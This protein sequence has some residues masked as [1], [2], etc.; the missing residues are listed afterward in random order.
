IMNFKSTAAFF[1]LLLG[2]L[3]LFGFMVAAKKT[4]VEESLLMPTLAAQPDVTIDSITVKRG[5]DEYQFTQTE[6]DV[7]TLRQSGVKPAIKVETFQVRKII[8]QIKSARKNDE[9]GQSNDPVR[10]ELSPPKATITLKGTTKDKKEKTWTMYL[11]KESADK[12]F[13][14]ANT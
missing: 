9:A 7:W 14:Y 2:M 5:N 12:A 11:G 1:G 13:V 10:Y 4:R 8:D 6:K 3:F